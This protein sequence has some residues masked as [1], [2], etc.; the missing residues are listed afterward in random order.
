[1]P[2]ELQCTH[3]RQ[4][5][6]PH[7]DGIRVDRR[8]GAI[9]GSNQQLQR[10]LIHQTRGHDDQ[11]LAQGCQGDRRAGRSIPE[12]DGLVD[13]HTA[14]DHPV[15]RI[16]HHSADPVSV[17]RAGDDHGVGHGDVAAQAR[18]R[19]RF[20][21]FEIRIEQRQISQ[22]AMR[23]HAQSR[24]GAVGSHSEHCRVQR[25]AAQAARQA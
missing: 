5:G 15:Q 24:R 20:V 10:G 12:D 11:G 23:A 14:R 13:E 19:R 8:F 4:Q 21:R 17:L 1:L 7:R 18:H 2:A 16:L 22:A 9:A 3:Q 25:C 6:V